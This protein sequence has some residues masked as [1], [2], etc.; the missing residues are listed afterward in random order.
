MKLRSIPAVLATWF[1]PR[2]RVAEHPQRSY[3]AIRNTLLFLI[4][5]ILPLT[6]FAAADPRKTWHG[7]LPEDPPGFDPAGA[8]SAASASVLEVI[9][10][11]LLTYDY[12]ARPSKLIPQA[13]DG[14]PVSSEGGKTWTVRIRKGIYFTPDP[15]FK[16]ARRELTAQDFAYSFKR[17]MDPAVRSQ[18]QF[19]FRNRFEGLD[20]LAEAASKTGRFDYDAKVAGLD[21]VDRYTLVFHLRAPDYRFLYL[22]AHDNAGAMARE[23]V[24]AHPRDIAA[25]P[26]GSG[27]YILTQWVPGTKIVLDANPNYRGFVW[28]F[29]AGS[30]PRDTALVAQMRGKRMPQIGHAEIAIVAE[31]STLWLSFNRGETDAAVVPPSLASHIFHGNDLSPELKTRNATA[32]RYDEPWVGYS[33][34]NF[35]DPA[36]GGYGPEKVALRRA[37]VMALNINDINHVVYA[38]SAERAQMPIPP[39]VWGYDPT[40]KNGIDYDPDLANKLLD[41]FEYKRGADGYRRMPGGQPL[42]L[43]RNTSAGAIYRDMDK[44]WNASMERIGIRMQMKTLSTSDLSVAQT[45]CQLSIFSWGWQADYPDGENFMQLAYGPNTGQS[46]SGCYRSAVYDR[47]YER[48]ERLPDGAER[49]KLFIDMSRRMEA[50]TVWALENTRFSYVIVQSWVLGHKYHP[51]LTS[52]LPYVDVLPH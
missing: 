36:V 29:A 50:D 40:Y 22:L 1:L 10:D 49:A 45:A 38:D 34:F 3:L 46:N 24:E 28:D 52:V 30:D 48:S 14:M 11:R 25:H 6:S 32:Y 18:Y 37:I 16:S 2:V 8:S 21:A 9:F 35:Q 43:V 15:A 44:V 33:T 39:G 26:V 47:L 27:P 23:V 17:F 19:L 20:E 41:R 51:I 31:P 5:T 12:L 7:V 42:V 13:A 4:A